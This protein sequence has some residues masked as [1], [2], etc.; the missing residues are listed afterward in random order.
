[1]GLLQTLC[2]PL[3]TFHNSNRSSKQIMVFIDRR[4]SQ[5]RSFIPLC[6]LNIR[7]FEMSANYYPLFLCSRCPNKLD[8]TSFQILLDDAGMVTEVLCEKCLEKLLAAAKVED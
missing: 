6:K 5:I 1:M 3:I 4:V 7:S 2:N 8:D